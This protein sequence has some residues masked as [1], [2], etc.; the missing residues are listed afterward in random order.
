[1]CFTT[2][3]TI[4]DLIS[5]DTPMIRYPPDPSEDCKADCQRYKLSEGYENVGGSLNRV[6]WMEI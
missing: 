5:A 6:Q 1:M 4:H 2:E 3:G